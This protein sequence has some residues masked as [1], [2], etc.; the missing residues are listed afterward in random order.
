M[1]NIL[2][3]FIAFF[4]LL[5]VTPQTQKFNS[6]LDFFYE[7]GFFIDYR[8]AKFFLKNLTRFSIFLLLLS[9]FF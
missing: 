6:V 1:L 7:S 8:E 5:L 4:V 3:F 9:S 2:R